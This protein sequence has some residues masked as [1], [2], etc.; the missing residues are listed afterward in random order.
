MGSDRQ[1]RIWG[2]GHINHI[3]EDMDASVSLYE[4]LFGAVFL[5][6]LIHI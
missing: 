2:I 3:V 6:S 5:L 1:L 4:R